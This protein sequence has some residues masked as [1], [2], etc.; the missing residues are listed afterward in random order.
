MTA[1]LPLDPDD[2]GIVTVVIERRCH[3]VRHGLGLGAIEVRIG[4]EPSTP[5]ER[6]QAQ[7]AEGAHRDGARRL[8]IGAQL[9]VVG[10]KQLFSLRHR[11]TA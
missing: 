6:D 5:R 2:L 1:G 4:H 8:C 3:E 11:N 7:R 9:S 10:R